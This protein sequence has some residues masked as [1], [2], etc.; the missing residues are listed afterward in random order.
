MGR[1]E[2]RRFFRMS[3]RKYPEFEALFAKS[4]NSH[5]QRGADVLQ[6]LMEHSEFINKEENQWMKQVMQVVRN[7]SLFFQ[8]QIRTKIMNEGWASYWH[9]KLYL[10]D[11]RIRSHEVE[12]ARVN[13]GVTSM[14]RVGLNPYALGMR[15][16]QYIE[17]NGRQGEIFVSV[18]ENRK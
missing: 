13:A 4:R 16:F 11:E 10:Q 3:T 18:S 14:P 15:I 7:T 5:P 6:Y 12:F 2:S 9:E 8:P 17:D 1:W